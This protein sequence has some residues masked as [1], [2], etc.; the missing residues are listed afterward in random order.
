MNPTPRLLPIEPSLPAIRQALAESGLCVLQAPPGAGKTTRVPL[1]LLNEPWLENRRIVMLEPRRVA[2]RAAAQR[3]A[4]TLGEAPGA[5]VG[6]RIRHESR[7]GPS[8]RIEVVT[9]GVL[10]RLLQKDP[11]L[12]AYGLVVFDEFHER[13]IHADLGLALTLQSRALLRND[14]RV[15]VM[16]ATLDGELVAALLGGA[17][18]VTSEGRSYSVETRY[19]PARQGAR[20]ESGVAAAVREAL[21]DDDGDILAFLPGAAEIGRTASLLHGAEADVVPLHGR[22]PQ[23]GQD[24]ALRPAA[25]GRR[26]VI[27]ATSIAETSLTLEGVRVVVDSGLA[28]VPRYSPRT[29]MTRLVT[30]RASRASV[31]Q[32]RGRAG[33]QAPGVCYRIWN[34]HDE[35]TFPPRS[36]PEI[37]ETDLAHLALELAIAG[38]SDPAELAWL[39]PPPAPALAE[40][41]ALLTDLGALDRQGR[42]TPHGRQLSRYALSPRLAHMVVRGRESGAGR[43]ACEVAAL[44]SERDLLRRSEDA[45]DADLATRLDIVAGRLE[46]AGADSETLRRVRAEARRCTESL[47][48]PTT[49]P[50]GTGGQ[51]V[52]LGALLALAYPDRVAQRRPGETGRFVM[53]GG[54]G[55]SLDPQPLSASPWLVIA[56]TD[57]KPRDSR[58]YLAA[59]IT[60]A[61]VEEV[62]ANEIVTEDVLGWDEG[63]RGVVAK[64]QRRLGVLVL[65]EGPLADADPAEIDRVVLSA[66]RREGVARLPWSESASRLRNRLAFL[67]HLDASWPDVSESALEADLDSWLA[68]RLRGRRRWDQLAQVDLAE[69][70]LDRLPWDLRAT[71][72]AWAPTHIEV[73]SGSRIPVD[74]GQPDAPVLAVRLQELFGLTETPRVGRG[75]VPLTLHLLSPA[76]RPVQVTR[77]L[78]GFW[79]TAYFEIR[80]ELKARYPKHHWPDDPLRAAPTRHAKRRRPEGT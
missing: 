8:T 44:L 66:I 64:R 20:P 2:A 18:I 36:V 25:P 6:Y 32:R 12:E 72:D 9:E 79:R 62:F 53:R 54:Q 71:V 43:L 45:P 73:P 42:V 57:G 48:E 14:L 33:R 11:A 39:N 23:S 41:R 26:K 27:L 69:G 61:E 70:L 59:A 13:S 50:P 17:P 68:P 46:R 38:V 67:H 35:P 47:G 15:L 52:S 49:A 30:V 24:R 34:V 28:R 10:T 3:M 58:I 74:Y 40:A 37:L 22:L 4:T 29:G 75:R 1:A 55:A 7:I 51:G 63:I 16:S 31:E 80:K 60:P 76:G 78:A 65:Q 21:A 77:D 5:T 56:E 19:R